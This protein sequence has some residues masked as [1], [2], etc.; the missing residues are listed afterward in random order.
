MAENKKY[1]PLLP[2]DGTIG[3][4]FSTHDTMTYVCNRD[5]CHPNIGMSTDNI[6]KYYTY[7]VNKE[8]T[9]IGASEQ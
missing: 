2:Y 3:E 7:V 8:P 5:L 4:Y 9:L 1:T 6:V